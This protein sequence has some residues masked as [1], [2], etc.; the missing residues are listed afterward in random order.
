M[1]KYLELSNKYNIF[2]YDSYNIE[3]IGDKKRI[4]FNF[5]VPGLTEYHPYIE[6][7]N[8]KLDSFTRYLAFHIGLIELISY[9]K[10]T[11]S[12]NVIIKAGYIDEEQ[13]AWFKKTYYYG[14]GELF[15]TNGINV[16]LE[17]F[18]NIRCEAKKEE[19]IYPEYKGTG[20]LIP[21]GGGKD[22]V[23]SLEILRGLENDTFIINPKE[24]TRR[25]S[26][27][28]GCEQP[29]AV[30]R[31]LD[32]N[33]LELNSKGFIN[34]HTPFSAC[35]SFITFL[36]A[37]THNKKYIALSNENSSNESN[38]EGTKINHQYSKTYE[39]E[40]DFNDYAKKYFKIDIHYFSLLRPLSEYQIAMLFSHYDEY[41]KTFKSCNV[42][43]KKEP[44]EWCCNCP[45]CL[46]VYTILAPFL[47]K[48]K[49]INIFGE[50][51][52][53]REDL[54]NTFIELCG[55]SKNKPFECVGTYSEVRYAV[56]RL[57][58]ELDELPFLLQYYKDHYKLEDT[59]NRLESKWNDEHNVP[60]EFEILV[61][62]EI[63]KYV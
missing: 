59:T 63:N 56:S 45:K 54:L 18:M 24:I 9:W 36:C 34:G 8:F 50:D 16:K 15:Y 21:I 19:I 27:L 7:D 60:K 46:F 13:I 49:L 42:G 41:H 23:V 11:C 28:G 1:D 20:N 37:Y 61:K 55:Y 47:Y 2:I 48:D 29:I 32:K 30:K 3:D 35:I 39:Y 57:I 17:D 51:L 58:E 40:K 12:K 38:I 22:S 6:V 52:F 25:C 14:L 62:E 33:M 5:I 10:C 43:S 44:W 53:A 4:T 31:V 26:Q